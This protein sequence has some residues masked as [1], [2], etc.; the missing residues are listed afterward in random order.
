[1]L[2]CLDIP[3]P[4]FHFSRNRL[5]YTCSLNEIVSNFLRG[6][7]QMARMPGLGPGGR[8]FKSCLPDFYK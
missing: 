7:V 4:S 5:K 1:M 6:V 3:V 2:S 8:R